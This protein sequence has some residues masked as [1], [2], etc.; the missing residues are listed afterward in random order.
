LQHGV[1]KDKDECDSLGMHV[2]VTF[3]LVKL[4]YHPC[5]HQRPYPHRTKAAG[6][7]H[8]GSMQ[9]TQGFLTRLSH[10]R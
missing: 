5:P 1:Y 8:R 4:Q 6:A 7:N 10:T 2:C 3:M 9:E